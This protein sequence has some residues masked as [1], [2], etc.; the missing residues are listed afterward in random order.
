M[1]NRKRVHRRGRTAWQTKSRA[2]GLWFSG[3][4]SGRGRMA[5]RLTAGIIAAALLAAC[6]PNGNPTAAS[7][8]AGTSTPADTGEQTATTV[9]AS[10]E[11]VTPEVADGAENNNSIDDPLTAAEANPQ[12]EQAPPPATAQNMNPACEAYFRRARACFQ[13]AP[14]GQSAALLQSLEATLGDLS[15]LDSEGCEAVSRQFDEMAQ[16]MACE[17]TLP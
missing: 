1:E 16:E 17:H 7:P 10:I 11:L 13:K 5:T 2:V 3:S 14:D 4:P 8:A 12:P 9:A 6:G 15:Q